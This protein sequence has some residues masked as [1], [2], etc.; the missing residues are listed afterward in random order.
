MT[1]ISQAPK[2]ASFYIQ[3]ILGSILLLAMAAVFL[4]SGYSKLGPSFDS[5]QWTFLDLGINSVTT[6]GIIA[7]LMI[8]LEFAL[9]LFLI[10][11]IFLRQFTYPAII[12]ILVIFIGYL[13]IVLIQQGNNGNC[14]CFGDKVV[15]KP[16]PSIGKNVLMI[17]ITVLLMFI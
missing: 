11:H 15:M 2:K 5:F 9:G 1:E 8:G 6:A 10:F 16:L 4:F 17:A 7:R 12:T 3:R 14:G 13:L